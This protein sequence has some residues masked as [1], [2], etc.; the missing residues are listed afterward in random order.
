MNCGFFHLYTCY[1]HLVYL[2]SHESGPDMYEP[3]PF[4]KETDELTGSSLAVDIGAF[5]L[6][7]PEM[8]V[9]LIAADEASASAGDAVAALLDRLKT[10]SNE[11]VGDIAGPMTS[12]GVAEGTAFGDPVLAGRLPQFAG[13]TQGILH[14]GGE[15]ELPLISGY[16]GPSAEIAGKG[17]P[18]FNGHV[19]SHVE[20]HAAALMRLEEISEASLEINRIPCLGAN[21]CVA[22]LPRML[23][24]GA[25][26]NIW[27]PEGY[28]RTFIGLPD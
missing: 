18:G 14:V 17:L 3:S 25:Q 24:E 19:L 10:G 20:A 2:Q 16:D 4:A 11:A 27:G 12:G 21:G 9:P 5:S 8:D 6:L 22:N 23:P 26:L 7:D 15:E 1:E 13:K 28:F